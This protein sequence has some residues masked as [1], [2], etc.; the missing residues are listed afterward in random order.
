MGFLSPRRDAVFFRKI[1]SS[2][3]SAAAASLMN[4]ALVWFGDEKAKNK[5]EFELMK[6]V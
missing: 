3:S 2:T 5:H 1:S 6:N 4:A